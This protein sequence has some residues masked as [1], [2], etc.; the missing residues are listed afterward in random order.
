VCVVLVVVACLA[1]ATSLALACR[2]CLEKKKTS[3]LATLLSPRSK[4]AAAAASA[5]VPTA[6]SSGS[7]SGTAT[8]TSTSSSEIEEAPRKPKGKHSRRTSSGADDVIKSFD[9]IM[10]PEKRERKEKRDKEKRKS[11]TGSSRDRRKNMKRASTVAT[12]NECSANDGMALV[13]SND[14]LCIALCVD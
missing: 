2:T 4:A 7:S 12:L 14:L 9:A 6:T 13:A 3:I 11:V 8:P 1:P 10:R 5:N